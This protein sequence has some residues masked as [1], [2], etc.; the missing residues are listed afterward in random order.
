MPPSHAERVKVFVRI[1]PTKA[2]GETPGALRQKPDGKGLV[3][4][5]E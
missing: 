1:R 5:R 4:H 3:I 2:E